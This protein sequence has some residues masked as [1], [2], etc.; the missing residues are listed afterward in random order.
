MP[1][2]KHLAMKQLGDFQM[3]AASDS[4]RMEQTFLAE[5][6]VQ[7]IDSEKQYPFD[8]IWFRITGYRPEHDSRVIIEGVE[9]LHDIGLSLIHI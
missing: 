3:R 5:N 9:L 2:Y 6:L 7:E 8:Y 4:R 1:K